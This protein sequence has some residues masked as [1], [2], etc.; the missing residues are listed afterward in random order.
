[1]LKKA[2]L[3]VALL[4]ALAF[5]CRA[6]TYFQLQ[7][8]PTLS[9]TSAAYLYSV[10][11]SAVYKMTL[12][13]VLTWMEANFNLAGA[14][15]NSIPY[16]SSAGVTG[17]ISPVNNAVMSTGATGI[18]VE[19][20]AVP[21]A[22]IVPN[23]G[24]VLLSSTAPT[25]ASGF[26]TNPSISN[27]NGTASFTVNVG[28]GGSAATGVITLPTATTGWNCFCNDISTYSSTVFQCRQTAS[29]QTTATIGEFTTAA[30]S[31]AW[32]S[33]DTVAVSCFAY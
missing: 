18:P 28:T 31:H 2:F 5:P 13:S 33:G 10:Y 15:V 1:M 6:Q 22:N 4:L 19:S 16:Q 23:G 7:N 17:Y 26:G 14:V 27:N 9:P 21:F 20:T 3:T 24:H 32:A 25:I 30:A 8:K 12:S 11:N 29:A